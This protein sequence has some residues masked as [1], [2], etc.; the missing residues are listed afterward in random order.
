VVVLDQ[1][2]ARTDWV[3][4]YP[5]AG[6]KIY[7]P[8]TVD[9]NGTSR[10]CEAFR[11]ALIEG[12]PT[13]KVDSGIW[14]NSLVSKGSRRTIGAESLDIAP[15]PPIDSGVNFCHAVNV[16]SFEGKPSILLTNGSEILSNLSDFTASPTSS[17]T[18]RLIEPVFPLEDGIKRPV[19]AYSLT[20]F[21]NGTLDG[22]RILANYAVLRPHRRE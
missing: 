17:L 6:Y 21:V 14:F 10:H 8:F 15:I 22:G 20:T 12:G 2:G 18:W 3:I 16:L 13:V 7:R 11:Q 9:I 19:L 4:S 1:I 5:L